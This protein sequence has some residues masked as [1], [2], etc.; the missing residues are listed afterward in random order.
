MGVVVV[1]GWHVASLL[2]W[3]NGAFNTEM[4]FSTRTYP[5]LP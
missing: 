2:T 3:I 5:S 4:H 1:N